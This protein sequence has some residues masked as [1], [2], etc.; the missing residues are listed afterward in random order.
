MHKTLGTVI[1]AVGLALA[2][3]PWKSGAQTPGYAPWANVGTIGSGRFSIGF[4]FT[5]TISFE[6]TALG[7]WDS[8]KDG[9]ITNHEVAIYYAQDHGSF[10]AGDQVPGAFATV[11]P[12]D[13]NGGTNDIGTGTDTNSFYAY[14]ALAAPVRL[15]PG[16][17]YRIAANS[18]P[19]IGLTPIDLPRYEPDGVPTSIAAPMALS[20][21]YY[22]ELALDDSAV[23][24]PTTL[25]GAFYSAPNFLYKMPALGVAAAYSVPASPEPSRITGTYSLGFDFTPT[26][27]LE[28]T[29]LGFW[30]PP[31]ISFIP[32]GSEVA[33]YFGQDFQGQLA[34]EQVTNA[35]ASVHQLDLAYGNTNGAGPYGSYTYH[36][37]ESPARLARGVT[38]RIAANTVAQSTRYDTIGSQPT[39]LA[40]MTV[41]KGW[42]TS[43]SD[44]FVSYPTTQDNTYTYPM[45]NFMFVIPPPSGTVI[46]LK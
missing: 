33:I 34:G 16:V 42:Y 12:A 32:Y 22:N 9:L 21:G 31:G 7:Y 15:Q 5:P 25:G 4:P 35:F 46:L 11:V 27:T 13:S 1:L 38:Y 19:T 40:P 2:L 41:G 45:P 17:T 20:K 26:A 24:Y 8:G 23:S 10:H 3:A 43:R 18:G 37:L 39:C 44:K 28:V 30:S 29:A 36:L 14:H 6:V